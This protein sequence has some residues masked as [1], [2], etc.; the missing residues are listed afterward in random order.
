[1]SLFHHLLPAPV[2][3]PQVVLLEVHLQDLHEY[4]ILHIKKVA[5]INLNRFLIVS[6]DLE[7]IEKYLLLYKAE[8]M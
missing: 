4:N 6:S 3:L 7:A 8:I 1:M 5:N 2:D